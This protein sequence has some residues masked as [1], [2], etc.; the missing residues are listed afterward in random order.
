MRNSVDVGQCRCNRYTSFF[1]L[2]HL[3]L[4]E[5]EHS[6][7]SSRTAGAVKLYFATG[8]MG[9]L[10][11]MKPAFENYGIEL[12]Q[13][14]VDVAEIDDPEIEKVA[15]RK[16]IDSFEELDKAPII[17]EDTGFFVEALGG[18]PGVEA[19]YFDETAGAEKILDLM[20]GEKNRRAYFQTAIACYIEGEVNVFTGRMEGHLSEEK[21]GESHPHLPYNSFFIPDHSD[22]ES[23]AENESLK[24]GEFHRKE[25]TE[26]FLKWFSSNVDV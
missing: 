3:S 6:F 22:G 9:K 18:F 21:K 17:V 5:L 14:E 4:Q 19:A 1:D 7:N 2:V 10:E 24:K 11:E 26:K 20:R 13:I 12:R 23:L 25:A 15:E 8:N 16:V